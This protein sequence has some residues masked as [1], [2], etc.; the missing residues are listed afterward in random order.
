L[1]AGVLGQVRWLLERHAD[2]R[3][4]LF[5]TAD[6][7][8]LSPIPTRKVLARVPFLREI[9]YLT[10]ILAKDTMRLSR[11]P[12]F[13][14]YLKEM[15]RAE[16]ALHGLHHVHKGTRLPVEFQEQDARECARM[17]SEAIAIFEEAGLDYARGMNPPGWDLTGELAEAMVRVGLK[18]VASARD[19][20]TP[21]SESARTCM[22]GLQGVSLIYPER[23]AGG[24]LLHFTSNFQATSAVERAIEIVE[25]GGLLA[26]KA[27]AVKNAMGHVA[28]DGLDRLYANYLDLIFTMLEERYGDSLWWTSM[29]EVAARCTEGAAALSRSMSEAAL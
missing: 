13:V 1:G 25:Q 16:V 19:I 3:V 10:K 15:E 24:R 17:L 14:R 27:H 23:I 6:W 4:T 21:V 8:E 22:S 20:L 2:L 12:E 9:F 5:T 26:I 11:H 28:L 7:R 29:G 18:F